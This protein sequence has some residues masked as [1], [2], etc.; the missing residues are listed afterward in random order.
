MVRSS[1]QRPLVVALGIFLLATIVAASLI[2]ESEQHHV[3]ETRARFAGLAKDH[4]RALETTIERALSA[5][6]ALAALV[7]QG[8]GKIANFDAVANQM[9]RLYP[10]V[11]ALELSPGGVIRQAVPLAGNEKAIGF[12]QL[13]SPGQRKEAMIARDTGKL[14]LAGPMNLVQGGLGAVGRLPVFLED[15]SGKPYFWGFTNV[16]IRFPEALVGARL[17]QLVEQGVDYELWRIQPD[18]GQKQ[19]IAASKS[20]AL[21]APVEQNLNLAYGNWTLSVAPVKGWWGNPVE[22]WFKAILG[23]I[24]SLLLSYVALLVMKLQAHQGELEQKVA[25]RTQALARANEDL[26]GRE[27]L[28]KQILD[29]SSVGIFLVD[30]TGRI[31]QANQRMAEMFGW[32]PDELVGNE[33]VALVHPEERET[34]RQKM[35]ELL[36]SAIPSVDVDRLYWRADHTAFWGHL[37]GKRFYDA[38]GEKRG[39]IGVVVDITERK[40][41]EKILKES[42]KHIRLLFNSG[43]D[44]IFVYEADSISGSPVGHFVE[45]NDM[46][47]YRL[48]YSREELLQMRPEDIIA[49]E[50]AAHPA[51]NIKLAFRREAVYESFHRTRDG[52]VIPV[53][54]NAHIFELYD[55]AL[56]FAMA[57]DITERKQMEEQVRELAFYDALTKLANRRLLND[58]LSQTMAF[59][60]RSGCHG[61]L[62]F[63]DLDNFKP[64]NDTHGHAIGDLLLIEVAQRLK[65]CVRETDTVARFGGD[66]FVVMLRDLNASKAESISN[67]EIVAEKIRIR[68]SG[69]YVLTVTRDGEA[70]TSVEH[71]CT[72]SVGVA[73]FLGHEASQDDVLK[74]ADAAM[75][76]AKEA[77]RNLIRFYAAKA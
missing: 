28:L 40:R 64:L 76:Q 2:W 12:D 14:T 75:Y 34:G 11:S 32:P 31:T 3:Q 47:C 6:Y 73:L 58:R 60:K 29:T 1:N 69:P 26:A 33:Y 37:T 41:T 7:R 49:A 8:N 65:S 39:L 15:A 63:L 9:L 77:G 10:G 24:F 27:A 23:L 68:I 51:P 74:W 35:L 36:A 16:V 57:R 66:E 70:A 20:S 54:V 19:I 45:V 52:R 42:E 46:A 13:R 38:S 18:N 71:H 72:A 44:P 67:A 61:A 30:M 48:G 59:S 53:E 43:N 21:I 62:M 55:K 25:E 56:V 17:P 50:A 4:A 5:T 22:F